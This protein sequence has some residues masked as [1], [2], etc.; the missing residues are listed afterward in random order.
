MLR[1]SSA[2]CANPNRRQPDET[3]K[4]N[5]PKDGEAG[6]FTLDLAGEAYDD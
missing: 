1:L 5:K 2:I 6:T 4:P 3:A